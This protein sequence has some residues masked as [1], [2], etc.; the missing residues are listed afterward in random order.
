AAVRGRRWHKGRR[1]PEP[2]WS[3]P[4]EA[5]GRYRTAPARSRGRTKTTR[6]RRLLA[7]GRPQT[8]GP[9]AHPRWFSPA[10]HRPP[11]VNLRS[12]PA[13]GIVPRPSGLKV[14]AVRPRCAARTDFRG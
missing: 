5:G 14:L 8:C 10:D 9:V 11:S 12:R 13:V 6:P 3:P 1:P 7:R 4:R 2:E